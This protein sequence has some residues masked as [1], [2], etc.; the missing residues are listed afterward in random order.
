M[1]GILEQGNLDSLIKYDQLKH[2]QK[3]N[4]VFVDYSEAPI[5]FTPT[6]KY[7][8]GTD[9]WDSSE[10]NRAPAWCDRV[11]WTGMRRFFFLF[12]FN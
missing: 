10:K 9:Q 12:L 8:V 7:D 3:Q 4:K 11:L 1:K 5:K 6:Y 2:Q